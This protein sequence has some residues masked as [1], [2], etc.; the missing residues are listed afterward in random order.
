M[1]CST[2]RAGQ[3]S[4]IEATP[5]ATL[6]CTGGQDAFCRGVATSMGF[7]TKKLLQG[8]S[9]ILF[10]QLPRNQFFLLHLSLLRP[11]T[12]SRANCRCGRNIRV[13]NRCSSFSGR[14]HSDMITPLSTCLF[15]LHCYGDN[16]VKK[17]PNLAGDP[18]N[19]LGWLRID[20]RKW[21]LQVY[22]VS[23]KGSELRRFRTWK[24]VE[25][26]LRTGALKQQVGTWKN[27]SSLTFLSG[28]ALTKKQQPLHPGKLH[29]LRHRK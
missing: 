12:C 25:V 7:L 26:F 8:L 16:P 4:K 18:S 29:W 5:T 22:G 19:F 13:W 27:L 9:P 17:I 28:R 21:R 10:R 11:L 6:N 2:A 1:C 15:L 3:C 24:S 20:L 23:C 14:H